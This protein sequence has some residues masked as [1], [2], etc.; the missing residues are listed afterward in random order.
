MPGRGYK[1]VW[2]LQK[3]PN[4][5]KCPK[6]DFGQSFTWLKSKEDLS[7]FILMVFSD[8]T[9]E[10]D[11]SGVVWLE[12]LHHNMFS[13]RVFHFS[14]KFYVS[15][16]TLSIQGSQELS[17]KEELFSLV[18]SH[19]D[20]VDPP[21]LYKA[22]ERN[23]E[24]F[25]IVDSALQQQQHDDHNNKDIE[26]LN[27]QDM[28]RPTR[29]WHVTVLDVLRGEICYIKKDYEIL[30]AKVDN[31][32]Q[33]LEQSRSVSS[34]PSLPNTNK[35]E[36][37]QAEIKQLKEM[38]EDLKKKYKSREMEKVQSDDELDQWWEHN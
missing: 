25:V 27:S 9:I 3:Y 36:H 5:Q 30:K 29:I 7:K 19:N 23:D 4:L 32:Q 26:L 31:H 16:N 14:F 38:K 17:A 28:S 8:S 35:T 22:D 12:D 33:Q 37:F 20:S 2:G 1:N 10:C 11:G 21:N 34:T 18:K 15:T 13:F 6:M 24:A